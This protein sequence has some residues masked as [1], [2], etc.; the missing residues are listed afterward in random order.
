MCFNAVHI[1]N[2]KSWM[3]PRL[4]RLLTFVACM[5]SRPELGQVQVVPQDSELE[6]AKWMPLHEFG[7]LQF[8]RQ[9][10]LH[11]MILD[12]CLAYAQGTYAGLQGYKVGGGLRMEKELLLTGPLDGH[13]E[14]ENASRL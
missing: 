3:L 9:R 1:A 5:L 10:P 14:H 8:L 11:S 2:C 12:R 6:A 7:E 13:S 4:P